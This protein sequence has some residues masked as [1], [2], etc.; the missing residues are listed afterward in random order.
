MAK[1]ELLWTINDPRGLNIVLAKDVWQEVV[2]KHPEMSSRLEEVRITVE[3]PEEIFFDPAT[4][5][6]RST[7][8][9]IFLYY[10]SGIK[11]EQDKSKLLLAVV[12]V[13]IE[14]EAEQG[15]VETAHLTDRK[16]RRAVLEWNR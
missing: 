14:V 1:R 9:R 10:R 4:T 7:G 12:K 6:Q 13:V 5:N 8:A 15:Y 11:I 3:Q 2:R 16:K